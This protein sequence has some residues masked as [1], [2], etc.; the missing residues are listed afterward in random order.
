MEHGAHQ[1]NLRLLA[2]QMAT[3]AKYIFTRPQLRDN[4]RL[5]A[6]TALAWLPWSF[7]T[8]CHRITQERE[9]QEELFRAGKFHF[10]CSSPTVS[11]LMKLPVLVEEV[12]E[13]AKAILEGNSVNLADELVQ[14]AAVCVGWLEALECVPHGL[15]ANRTDEAKEAA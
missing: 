3:I 7:E 5:L 4:L 14:V 6:V 10:T 15:S 13:V 2:W 1:T 11:D 12:G 9:R 8:S